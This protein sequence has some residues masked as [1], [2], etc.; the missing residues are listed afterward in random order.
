MDMAIGEKIADYL[1]K[2]VNP[3]QILLCLKK[4]LHQREIVEQHAT[5][6]YRQEFQELSDRI[7][8]AYSAPDFYHIHSQL[9]RW[10]L[11]LESSDSG[12]LDMLRSQRRD[13]E[14]RFAR[15]V[16]EN[17]ETWFDATRQPA[18]KRNDSS[19]PIMSP[20]IMKTYVLP[21]LENGQKVCMIVF[22]NLR[23]D[24]WKVLQNDMSEMFDVVS[25]EQYCS[26]QI[27]RAHV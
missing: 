16:R 11:E 17:Y 27:G 20:D 26:I 12:M 6:G 13:A 8:N 4:H 21:R 7:N 9:T 18:I 1:I 14:Q 10:E 5:S 22:D 25:E 15:F 2:P 24:Q 19:T 23:Y 3:N